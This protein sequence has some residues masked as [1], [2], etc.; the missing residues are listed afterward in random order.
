MVRDREE[1]KE[2]KHETWG[3]LQFPKQTASL[4]SS[5]ESNPKVYKNKFRVYFF[6]ILVLI[7][8]FY[9]RISDS[10]VPIRTWRTVPVKCLSSTSLIVRFR[11]LFEP[12]HPMWTFFYFLD[13]NLYRVV[14]ISPDPIILIFYFFYIYINVYVGCVLGMAS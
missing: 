9:R 5:H 4:F 8:Y 10:D 14:F 2:K 7:T 3:R 6:L 11:V 1:K 13:F 12:H